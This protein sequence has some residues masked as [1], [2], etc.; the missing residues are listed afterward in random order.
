M[1][2][3][4]WFRHNELCEMRLLVRASS[5]NRAWVGFD[6]TLFDTSGGRVEIPKMPRHNLSMQI[7]PPI[8]ATCRCE[9]P[10]DRRLQSPGDIDFVPSGCTAVW[11]DEGP[12]TFLS[13]NIEHALV[14]STADAMGLN[15]DLVSFE[16]ELQIKDP[17]LQHI[18]WALKSELEARD[19]FD[20]LYA[21]GLGVA[22]TTHL[23][24][25]FARIRRVPARGLSKRQLRAVIDYVEDHL[26]SDLSL[27]ELASIAGVSAS[28]FKS[29]FKDSTGV[30]PH[31]YVVRRRVQLATHLLARGSPQLSEIAL[32][33]GFADQSHMA[34]CMRR[35]LGVTPSALLRQYR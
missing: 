8:I 13:V 15:S 17:K 4:E 24:R 26:C 34:R 20:R 28:H 9:G 33:A 35:V 25:R 11:E 3:R 2:E 19:P 10:I 22:L 21:E 30:P 1:E 6:A 12:T 27:H 14:R 5:K 31:K 18:G 29:L 7:G 23:L 32:Q 16:P